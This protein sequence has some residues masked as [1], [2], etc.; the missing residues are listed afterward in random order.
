MANPAQSPHLRSCRAAVLVTLLMTAGCNSLED[1]DTADGEAFC[2]QITLGSAYRTGFS[3]RVQLRMR[4]DT[5]RIFTGESPGTVSSFE[6]GSD[7]AEPKRLL[8]TA[9]LRPF[10]P[11]AHDALSDLEFGDGR[12]R[13]LV[14]AVSPAD[15]TAEALL[16]VVSLRTDDSVEVRLLRPGLDLTADQDPP[17]E[18][19]QLFGVFVLQKRQDLCGF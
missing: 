6:A 5:S 7:G 9:Q 3:P 12:E 8:D 2:G 14:Y 18:R 17:P 19:R 16:A 15:P 13:N 1:F 4:L 10:A 11:L